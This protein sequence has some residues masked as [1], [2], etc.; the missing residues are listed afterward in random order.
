MCGLPWRWPR[1]IA[2]DAEMPRGN[3]PR[4]AI[5][6][7]ARVLFNPELLRCG[8]EGE[9]QRQRAVDQKEG[10]RCC[11]SATK[12]WCNSIFMHDYVL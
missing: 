2:D 8:S 5:A 4:S 6:T 7:V 3:A 1:S 11:T 9:Q 10:V 12:K